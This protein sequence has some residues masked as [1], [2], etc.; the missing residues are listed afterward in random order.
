MKNPYAGVSPVAAIAAAAS[1]A[2]SSGAER[3]RLVVVA[4]D[5]RRL[6]RLRQAGEVG[7]DAHAIGGIGGARRDLA[8]AVVARPV[9]D[10]DADAA[11][12]DGAQA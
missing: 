11:V 3:G 12:A 2:C 5:G 4:V 7:I 8:Q 10:R 6:G 1:R 9:R